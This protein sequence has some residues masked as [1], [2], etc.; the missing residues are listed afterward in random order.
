MLSAERVDRRHV[1]ERQHRAAGAVVR[2]FHLDQ[3][4]RQLVGLHLRAD[5]LGQGAGIH[6]PAF[7]ADRAVEQAGDLGDGAHFA[8]EDV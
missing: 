2:R 4:G 3:G 7:T 6:R 8:L 5:R 1:I